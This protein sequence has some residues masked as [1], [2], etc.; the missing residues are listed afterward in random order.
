M[1][2]KKY[3]DPYEKTVLNIGYVGNGKYNYIEDKYVYKS[4]SHMITR[5]YDTKY[6]DKFPTYVGCKVDEY[7]HNFQNFAEWYY[8]NIW[9]HDGKSYLDKDILIKGNKTYS[10]NNC[11]LVDNNINCMFTKNYAKRGKYPIGVSI[12]KRY[13][14]IR[15]YIYTE[16][17][18]RSMKYCK[19]I[20]EAFMLYKNSKERYIKRVADNYKSKYPNFPNKLYEA[21]YNYEVEIDD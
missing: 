13:G 21:L 8:N 4:W 9:I 7:F 1:I 17:N 3:K 19:S 5:C 15:A 16:D 11:I 10:P 12:D 20:D 6:S 18:K 14:S 2:I